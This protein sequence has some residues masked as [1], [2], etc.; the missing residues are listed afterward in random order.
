MHF[1]VRHPDSVVCRFLLVG[2]TGLF[3]LPLEIVE[4]TDDPEDP[5]RLPSIR[6]A[7]LEFGIVVLEEILDRAVKPLT[8]PDEDIDDPEDPERLPSI[9][10]AVLEFG[11]VVLEEILD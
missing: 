1:H 6:L 2:F 7:V 9:C 3:G 10:L 5:E 8:E 11:I 4:G